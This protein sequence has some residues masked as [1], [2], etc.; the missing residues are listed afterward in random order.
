MYLVSPVEKQTEV[1][2]SGFVENA[3]CGFAIPEPQMTAS[4]NGTPK[5]KL[6]LKNTNNVF[7]SK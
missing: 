1:T 6:T 3:N 5:L 7:M 2:P 4:R